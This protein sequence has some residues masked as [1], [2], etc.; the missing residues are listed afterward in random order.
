M[1]ETNEK[2][3]SEERK[4]H[5]YLKTE[6]KGYDIREKIKDNEIRMISVQSKALKGHAAKSTKKLNYV[7][8]EANDEKLDKKE[9]EDQMIN[10]QKQKGKTI[11]KPATLKSSSR[12]NI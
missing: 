3:F 6:T 9:E 5:I 12:L 11:L 4:S 8:K 10:P 2:N 1:L 7:L